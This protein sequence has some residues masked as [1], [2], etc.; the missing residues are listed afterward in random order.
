MG[1]GDKKINTPGEIHSSGVICLDGFRLQSEREY[2]I[3]KREDYVCVIRWY[4]HRFFLP[5]STT[6]VLI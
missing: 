5:F 3:P 1:K 6:L 4:A 2:P